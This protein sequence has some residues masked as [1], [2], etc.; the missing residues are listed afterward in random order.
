PLEPIT[1]EKITFQGVGFSP[2]EKIRVDFG[3]REA[4]LW[5]ESNENGIFT[6]E[7]TIQDPVGTYRLVAIG[8][9]TSNAG[10]I[11]VNVVE[12]K[13]EESQEEKKE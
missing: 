4:I 11:N 6:A 10:I 2:F 5:T 9:K 3:R 8:Y 7:Y 13:E 1:G 12:P